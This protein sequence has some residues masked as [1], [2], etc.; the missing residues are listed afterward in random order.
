MNGSAIA[1]MLFAMIVLW[2]G[3]AYCISVALKNQK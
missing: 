1:M 2:G 3:A